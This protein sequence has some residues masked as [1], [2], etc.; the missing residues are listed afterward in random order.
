MASIIYLVEHNQ[1]YAQTIVNTA[2]KSGYEIFIFSKFLNLLKE[3][4]KQQPDAILIN[5]ESIPV[6]DDHLRVL[7]NFFT[8]VYGEK[9][10][11][12]LKHRF[13]DLSVSRVVSGAYAQPSALVQMLKVDKFCREDLR[14]MINKTITHTNLTDVQLSD[15]ISTTAMNKRNLVLKFNDENW[16]AKIRIHQGELVDAHSPGK[17]GLSAALDILQHP[18]GHLTMQSF[19][20]ENESSNLQ[21]SVFGLLIES[22]F[23]IDALKAFQEKFG[24]A[25]KVFKKKER[26][27]N[28]NLTVEELY[29]YKLINETE[30]LQNILRGSPYP[31]LQTINTLEKLINK[32]IV[33][34]EEDT[35][36][37]EQFT[38]EDIKVISERL[39][40]GADPQGQILVL[41]SS[42]YGKQI[43]IETVANA[44]HTKVHSNNYIDMTQIQLRDNLML[45]L[46]GI[47]INTY[48]QQL[49]KNHKANVLATFF[50]FDFAQELKFEYKKYFIRQF[51][52]DYE[53]P[54]VIGIVNNSKFNEQVVAE[55]RRKLEIPPEI[56]IVPFDPNNFQQVKQLF[57]NLVEVQVDI[58][59]H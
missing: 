25:D 21:T 57:Y 39:H 54:A 32:D 24:K 31:M 8:I 43:L 17:S 37:S 44:C 46:L 1:R 48:F 50:I 36:K 28:N 2:I 29:I 9:I 12:D 34:T 38:E 40:Q 20:S 45:Q 26:G 59:K 51:L 56:N 5:F 16:F 49:I 14:V 55:F 52:T 23:Q 10:D 19:S 3:I 11:Y 35:A 33:T 13:Y 18:V 53:M 15:V 22:Q 58:L 41:S 6:S 27:W 30:S 7:K 42:N 47:P 4:N